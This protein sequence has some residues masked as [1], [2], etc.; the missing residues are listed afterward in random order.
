MYCPT[1]SEYDSACKLLE[2]LGYT[3]NQFSPGWLHSGSSFLISYLGVRAAKY[4]S[5]SRAPEDAIVIPYNLDLF[6]ALAAMREGEE[7][8]PGELVR[9]I[10]ST[11]SVGIVG[12]NVDS[13]DDSVPVIW[14]SSFYDER[15]PFDLYSPTAVK[16]LTVEEI[17]AQFNIT[18][19]TGDNETFTPTGYTVNG[20]A[21][22]VDTDLRL[23]S[24]FK[25]G[26]AIS[27]K[28]FREAEALADVT[29]RSGILTGW[30]KYGDNTIYDPSEARFG[31]IENAKRMG[32][33]IYPASDIIPESYYPKMT[34]TETTTSPTPKLPAFLLKTA[35]NE[36][37]A[38][39]DLKKQNQHEIDTLRETGRD[40]DARVEELQ[41]FLN[42]YKA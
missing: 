20:E 23:L 35:E 7:F 21:P 32:Y 9:H 36:L 24:R 5:G 26:E 14:D 16:K 39:R 10:F 19:S 11:N 2:N 22:A 28:S 34:K 13:F 3:A 6:K 12:R 1:M 27:F 25:T 41:A 33:K 17:L 29:K 40:F 8:Y 4:R 18:R 38:L 30:Q 42:H 31:H 15:Q 37:E